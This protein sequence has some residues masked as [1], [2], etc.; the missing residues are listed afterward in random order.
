MALCILHGVM[1]ITWRY[2]YY[3]AVFEEKILDL[4][5]LVR[6]HF[7]IARI[8][9]NF[10]STSNQ[11]VA[12]KLHLFLCSSSRIKQILATNMRLIMKRKD[13]FS[14]KVINDNCILVLTL[15]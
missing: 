2:V 14:I 4:D 9:R 1:Y 5:D 15:W 3:I 8:D 6:I 11:K 13:V 12:R 10:I 7:Q